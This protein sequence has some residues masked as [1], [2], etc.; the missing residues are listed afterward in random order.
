MCYAWGWMKSRCCGSTGKREALED[1]QLKFAVTHYK[2]QRHISRDRWE[3]VMDSIQA[4]VF[5]TACVCGE[6]GCTWKLLFRYLV[7][8][9]T[10]TH[11]DSVHVFGKKCLDK[12]RAS[13]K[14]MQWWAL[15]ILANKY[16]SKEMELLRAGGSRKHSK[17][18]K[19]SSVLIEKRSQI[20]S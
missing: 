10:N 20:F 4:C 6:V 12:I 8:S 13:L 16:W 7:S 17:F 3:C 2:P 5:V 9:S 1:K 11:R 15:I 18:G 14:Q 19:C